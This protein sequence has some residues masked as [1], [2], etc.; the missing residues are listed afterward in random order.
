MTS[1]QTT[2]KKKETWKSKRRLNRAHAWLAQE[3]ER[4]KKNVARYAT[5]LATSAGQ[6]SE[7]FVWH[8]SAAGASIIVGVD[9]VVD[10]IVVGVL[11][12]VFD[13]LDVVF[14]GS[15]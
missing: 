3:K 5:Y 11:V 10:V 12:V 6:C 9:V 7:P 13:V 1:G 15:A 4:K 8:A 14:V 2:N